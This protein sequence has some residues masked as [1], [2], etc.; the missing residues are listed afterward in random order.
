M[1]GLESESGQGR[2]RDLGLSAWRG[3]GR[4]GEASPLSAPAWKEAVVRWGSVSPPK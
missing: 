4:R 2:L 1:R 3:G